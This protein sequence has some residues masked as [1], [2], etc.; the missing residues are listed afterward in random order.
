MVL[1]QPK[2]KT[3]F[4]IIAV[5]AVA[6]LFSGCSNPLVVAV[7]AARSAALWSKVTASPATGVVSNHAVTLS[8]SDAPG[9]TSYNLYWS[10]SPNPTAATATK[11]AG[12]SSPYVHSGLAN[13][14]NYNYFLTA[15]GSTG[16]SRPSTVTSIVP[17]QLVA[18]VTSSAAVKIYLV[19]K[20]TGAFGAPLSGPSTAYNL[21]LAVDPACK[22]A[23]LTDLF[24]HQ[25]YSF[26]I[27]SNTGALTAVGS[28]VP[29]GNRPEYIVINANSSFVYV[30]NSSAPSAA[31]A[32]VSSGWSVSGYKVSQTDGSLAVLSGFPVSVGDQ[33]GGLSVSP[34]RR[35]LYLTT[36][37][38][39]SNL[40]GYGINTSTG[41]L[42]A[43]SGS[44]TP[45]SYTPGPVT[46]DST[47]GFLYL[48]N[49]SDNVDNFILKSYPVNI[50]T[51][52]PLASVSNMVNNSGGNR[53]IRNNHLA[54]DPYGRFLFVGNRMNENSITVFKVTSGALSVAKVGSVD[55]LL[56]AYEPG[57]MTV[58]TL[59]NSLYVANG[60]AVQSYSINQTTGALTPLASIDTGSTVNDISVVSLP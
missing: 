55:S 2:S 28:P 19:D 8:W 59:G 45:V 34:D 29:T 43:I 4:L 21:A 10:T 18:Y 12:V 49:H 36:N 53:N 42:A 54:M 32:P 14:I 57:S 44:P 37:A 15:V 11:I 47:S 46:F 50:T 17:I 9:A 33:I 3:H 51:G 27:N 38:W 60:S 23:Y 40:Y 1:M 31:P 20:T 35:F 52:V 26:I 13:K 30:A 25:V 5:L 6:T 7:V 56:L 22:Y 41:A 39:T 48:A 16:E 58:D 24:T